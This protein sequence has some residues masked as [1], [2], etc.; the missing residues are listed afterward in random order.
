M[1]P[2]L[3]ALG[4]K[5]ISIHRYS[6][7]VVVFLFS[8]CYVICVILLFILVILIITVIVIIVLSRNMFGHLKQAALTRNYPSG[9]A[10][11]CL[12]RASEGFSV[13]HAWTQRGGWNWKMASFA[14][15]N[16]KDIIY[17]I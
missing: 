3:A 4:L 1:A 14:T 2:Q 7:F 9:T 8:Y 16:Y 12:K 6:Y 11:T 17:I 13:G 10:S 5:L 15:C